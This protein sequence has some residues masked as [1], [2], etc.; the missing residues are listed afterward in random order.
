MSNSTIPMETQKWAFT[1]PKFIAIIGS[2]CTAVAI[3]TAAYTQLATEAYVDNK[4]AAVTAQIEAL[5]TAQKETTRTMNRLAE[6]RADTD[7][8]LGLVVK[9]VSAQYIEQVDQ[10]EGRDR[11]PMSARA[12]EA[13][14]LLKV[15]PDDPLAGV[16]LIAE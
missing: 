4:H 8:R 2:T 5:A 3:A 14:K 15:D 1:M 7:R 12:R 11:K 13:A 10:T 9:L 16:E 6:E